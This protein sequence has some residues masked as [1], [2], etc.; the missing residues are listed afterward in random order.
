MAKEGVANIIFA[1]AIVMVLAFFSF[2]YPDDFYWKIL[3]SMSGLFLAF[4]LYFFRDPERLI[5]VCDNNILS[6]GDGTIISIEN[7]SDEWIGDAV[8]VTMFLSPF[9]VHINRIPIDGKI[10]FVDY[11]YGLFKAAF[12]PDASEVNEQSVVGLSHGDYRIKFS[13]I[14]GVVAR[15]IINYLKVGDN[16]S[17]GERYGMIKFGS[18]MDIILPRTS[19]IL[20][21]AKQAVKGGI[22]ILATRGA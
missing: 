5:K 19:Q 20:I 16:V 10:D 17:Q 1:F 6:P 7:V 14:S 3:S 22:T 2:I 4:T 13:Q 21:E 9:N 18:R 8:R 15:R 11:K 12:A